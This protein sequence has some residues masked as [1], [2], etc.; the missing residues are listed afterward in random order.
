MLPSPAQ[1]L[2]A[3]QRPPGFP[4]MRQRWAGLLFL[5]WA[6]DPALIAGRLPLGLSVDTFD[7]MAWLG[8]VPFYM[9]RVRPVGLPPVPWLSWFH[10]LNVRTYVHDAEGNPGVWFFSLDCNQPIAVEIARR[11]F[12]LPYEHAV[13]SSV[14]SGNRIQ[15]HSRRK[16]SGGLD[17]AYDYETPATTQAAAPGTLEWFLAE[18]Y[19]LFSS[20]PSGDL[21]CGRVYH[22]PYQIA[23]AVCT[24]WSTEPLRLDGFPEPAEAPPS[25]LVAAPVDVEI[26]PLRLIATSGR[27]GTNTSNAGR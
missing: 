13:M 22:T 16:I 2:A 10:E 26:F 27:P 14:K 7:G 5:H 6:V 18:R 23:P 20:N 12:R 9:E 4:V 1:R 3:C 19:L 8:V 11:G 15:Y 21:F 24:R 17:A 25:M